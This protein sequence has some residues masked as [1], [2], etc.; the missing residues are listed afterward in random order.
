MISRSAGVL[1]EASARELAR[2]YGVDA[3]RSS[4]AFVRSRLAERLTDAR[5]TTLVQVVH[6]VEHECALTCEDVVFRRT[7]LG[8]IGDPGDTAI[9]RVAHVMGDLLGWDA[10]R[11]AVESA[12]CRQRFIQASR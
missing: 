5:D 12:R 4:T 9:G 1:S 3:L 6:A 2:N 11:C 10:E 7:G 8:T